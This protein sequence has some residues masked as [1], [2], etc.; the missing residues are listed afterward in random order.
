MSNVIWGISANSHDAALSVV[1]DNRLVFAAHSERYSR[2]KNDAY[3][4]EGII[5]DALKHGYPSEIHFFENEVTKKFRQFLSGQYSAVFESRIKSRLKKLGITSNIHYHSHH[6]SH[7]AGGYYTSQFDDAA[8]VVID[9]IGEFETLTIWNARHN[10]IRKLH[11]QSY[12]DSIGL[13]YTAMTQRLG[14]KPQEHEYILMGMA[15]LGDPFKYYDLIKN[16][17]ISKMPNELDPYVEFKTNLHRG[18]INWRPDI[19]DIYNIAAA[20]QKLYEDMLDG[21]LSC[22][23]NIVGSNNLVLSGGVALNCV[24]N[25]LAFKH[26]KDVWIIPNPGDAGSSL[27]AIC[28]GL[29][30][31]IDF[32]TPSLGHNIGSSYPIDEVVSQLLENKITAVASN[33]AEFG[34][35]AFGYRSILADPRGKDVKDRVNQIKKREEFRPFAPMILEEDVHKYFEVEE[36]FSSPYMQFTVKCKYPENYPAIVHYDNTSRVQTVTR[37]TYPEVYELLKKWKKVS[38]CPMLLN[39][40]LNIKGEPLVNTLEDAKRWQEKYGLHVCLGR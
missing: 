22:A 36:G 6:E 15:E 38:G 32:T 11:T 8:I 37:E 34:P 2:I 5:E 24:A 23:K 33:K 19:Q 31:R 1:I 17:F 3:L 29:K 18:C 4:N 39:T 16:D 13:W 20:T 28:A 27:G 35:R 7:A 14:L 12:P 40:S 9:S 30:N 10:K 25:S 26:F 21:I